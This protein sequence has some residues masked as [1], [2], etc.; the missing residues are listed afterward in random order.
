[1]DGFITTDRSQNPKTF[2]VGASSGDDTRP[3]L[4]WSGIYEIEGDTLKLCFT[5]FKRGGGKD[6]RPKEFKSNPALLVVLRRV[7]Q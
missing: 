7:K 2:D 3:N 6:E 5:E 1:V 4:E